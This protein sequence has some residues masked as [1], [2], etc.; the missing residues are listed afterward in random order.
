MVFIK[1]HSL[2]RIQYMPRE[3]PG[4]TAHQGQQPKTLLEPYTAQA[5][6]S[7]DVVLG[8]L[9]VYLVLLKFLHLGSSFIRNRSICSQRCVEPAAQ[10]NSLSLQVILS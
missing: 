8:K 4:I 9:I 7:S 2:A 6:A 5:K 1:L 3:I 10:T